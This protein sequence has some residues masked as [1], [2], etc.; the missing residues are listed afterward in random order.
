[1]KLSE[2][3]Q[4]AYERKWSMINA[5]T[6]QIQLPENLIQKVGVIDEDIN[7]N[8]ISV[9]TPD[10]TNDPIESFIA[11]KWYIHNGKDE[12]YRFSMTFRDQ[13]QLSLYKKFYSIYKISKENFF[14]DVAMNININKD[15][16]WKSENIKLFA[17]YSGVLIE[18]ISNLSFSNDTENQ[19]AEFTVSFKCVQIN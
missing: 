16:D 14:D 17:S 15:P 11:N 19:I 13:D 8:I 1:V 4:K 5:F 3:I 7:L 2:G 10:I 6:V 18:A 9:N 12:L